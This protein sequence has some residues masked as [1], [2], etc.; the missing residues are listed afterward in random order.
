MRDFVEDVAV[1]LSYAMQDL[2]DVENVELS[3]IHI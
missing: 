1:L 2:P 3:L